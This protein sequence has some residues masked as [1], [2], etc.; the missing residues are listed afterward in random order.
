VLA[1]IVLEG[2][3]AAGAGNFFDRISMALLGTRRGG[4]AKVA[5][6]SSAMFGDQR[7]AVANVVSSGI[8]TIPLMIRW[9]SGPR[10]LP[11]EATPDRRPV[12]PPGWARLRS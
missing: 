1:F 10:W 5:V 3:S 8:V 12:T 11:I 9:A 6:V 4:P 2:V 7:P